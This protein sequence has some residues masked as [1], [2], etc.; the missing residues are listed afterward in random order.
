LITINFDKL[1]LLLKIFLLAVVLN[2]P[3]S[4]LFFKCFTDFSIVDDYLFRYSG[5]LFLALGS[6]ISIFIIVVFYVTM[7]LDTK[8]I[9]K[10]LV[11]NN[12]N[13]KKK[14]KIKIMKRALDSIRNSFFQDLTKYIVAFSIVIYFPVLYY[15]LFPETD[16][17]PI[18]PSLDK[19]IGIFI[20]A[21]T[22]SVA[23]L[24]SLFNSIF[25][26]KKLVAVSE[27]IDLLRARIFKL[28]Y[29]IEEK[30]HD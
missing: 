22:H 25:Y 10:A 12:V 15:Y 27:K 20:L 4:I 5:P 13:L 3:G 17:F 14:T 18:P 2:L 7:D 8:V 16:L 23:M 19:Y 26:K 28:K 6:S 30:N 21:S 24:A 1:D 9:D 29:N 11:L